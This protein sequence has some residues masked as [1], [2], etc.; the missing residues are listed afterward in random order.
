MKEKKEVKASD[1]ILLAVMLLG[2]LTFVVHTEALSFIVQIAWAAMM[3]VG[4][5]IAGALLYFQGD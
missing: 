2:S 5:L 1:V 3:I 4:G